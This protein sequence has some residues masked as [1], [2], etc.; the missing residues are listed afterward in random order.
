MNEN[1]TKP[2]NTQNQSGCDLSQVGCATTCCPWRI[3]RIWER[4]A[5][6]VA[7]STTTAS[8]CLGALSLSPV[9]I[10]TPRYQVTH[11]NTLLSMGAD[12]LLGL[13]GFH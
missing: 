12:D 9:A 5:D 13:Q 11:A 1:R 7:R 3:G 4:A 8:L 2:I 6:L 10:S